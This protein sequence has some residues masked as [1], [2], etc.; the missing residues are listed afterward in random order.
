VGAA[1]CRDGIVAGSHSHK[2]DTSLPIGRR[3]APQLAFYKVV[4][5]S[6]FYAPINLQFRGHATEQAAEKQESG[7]Q[8]RR[9]AF[10]K[11]SIFRNM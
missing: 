10:E 11:R 6:T 7:R 1:S 5:N 3:S 4:C 9:A 8:T 2:G